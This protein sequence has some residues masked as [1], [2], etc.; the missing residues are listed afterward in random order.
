[1]HHL[2]RDFL[3][4][5]V[6]DRDGEPLGRVDA[7]VLELREG[8]PPRV[9]ELQLGLVP[10][11]RRLGRRAE[12]LAETLH[13]RWGVRPSARHRI[14]WERVLDFDVHR[15]RV[16]ESAEDSP[17]TAWERWLRRHLIE[18]IPGSGREDAS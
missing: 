17:A 4:K 9:A 18:R 12:A 7:L 16:D 8:R 3:D 10:L 15:I 2:I 6:V 14:P 1:M 5:Q 13:R 11:A